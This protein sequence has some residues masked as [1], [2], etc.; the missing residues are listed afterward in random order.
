MP[1][2]RVWRAALTDA[3]REVLL[4]HGT[5]APSCGGLLD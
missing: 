3:E 2:A 5:E 1:T 4:R